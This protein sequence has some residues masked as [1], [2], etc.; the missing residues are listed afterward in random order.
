MVKELKIKSRIQKELDD[1][2]R[3]YRIYRYSYHCTLASSVLLLAIMLCGYF[4]LFSFWHMTI[5]WWIMTPIL[6]FSGINFYR[7]Y[8][9]I[10]NENLEVR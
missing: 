7:Y 4:K 1:I 6:L 3:E 2:D 8:N 10:Y 9:K 5:L